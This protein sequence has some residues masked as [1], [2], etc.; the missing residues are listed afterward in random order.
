MKFKYLFACVISICLIWMTSCEES[1]VAESNEAPEIRSITV[2]P[3]P[4]VIGENCT[5]TVDANDPEDDDLTFTYTVTNGNLTGDGPSVTYT[6][7][8]APAVATVIVEVS[9]SDGKTAIDSIQITLSCNT[10]YNRSNFPPS[11]ISFQN[12]IKPIL[13]TNGCS[14]IFCHGG[15]DPPS[16]YSVMSA[17]ELMGPGDEATELGVCN[18][19]RGDTTNSYLLMKLNNAPGIIGEQMPFGA[20]PL[21]AAEIQTISQWI[22]EGAPD[23]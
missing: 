21:T 19:V 1:M 10:A 18:I 11:T 23:N 2:S 4:V 13:E 16:S 14:S 5:I 9:D 12:D 15:E 17:A 3:T 6:A 7:P 20:D 22:F 8:A